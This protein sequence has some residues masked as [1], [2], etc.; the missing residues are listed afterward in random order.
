MTP[1][2]HLVVWAFFLFGWNTVQG[3][4]YALPTNTPGDRM[5]VEYFQAQTARLAERS[6]KDVQSLDDWKARRGPYREQLFE[7]LGLSPQQERTDLKPVITG[8]AEHEQFVVENLHFQSRPGLYVTANLYL[9]KGLTKP[10]PTILYLSGHG[11]VISNGVSYGN[12]V[13]YQHHGA[14]FARNGYIC[15]ILDT[16]QLG[17]I[18]GLHH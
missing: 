11:P 14:W 2:R 13:A 5:L 8:K 12:K 16:L 6:L 3:A 7:M 15:L 1:R 10:A 17:E 18:Q 9:P 4:D